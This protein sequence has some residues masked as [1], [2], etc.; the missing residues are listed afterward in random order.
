MKRHGYKGAGDISHMMDVVL[1]WDAT[2]EV[3]EDWMYEAVAEKYVKDREMRDWMKEVNPY[4]RQNII[5]KLLE[6]IARGMW[7]ADSE[8][9]DELR[10]AYLEIE[11]DLEERIE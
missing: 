7:Q 8:M 1:G 4:A 9:E 5:E 6:A 10:E 2:A 3:I 11:G